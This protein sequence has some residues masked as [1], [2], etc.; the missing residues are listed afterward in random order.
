MDNIVVPFALYGAEKMFYDHR[1]GPQLV[2]DKDYLYC[3]YQA[4]ENTVLTDPYIVRYS[5]TEKRWAGPFKV[6]IG[7]KSGYDHHLTP[8]MWFDADG[9]IHVLF[10]CHGGMGTHRVSVKPFDIENFTDGPVI[11]PS[12]SY[13]HVFRME[14]NDVGL[15]FRAFGHMGYWG[16]CISHDGGYTWS[17]M[18]KVVDFD[19][20]P[21]NDADTWAGSYHTVELDEDGHTLHVAF[22]YFDE[23]GIWILD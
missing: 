19:Q 7:D 22:T 14:G 11:S 9:Y 10:N 21:L 1:M 15:F 6:G 3:V 2:R 23:R 16:Y 20:D 12:M 5:I 4:G 18:V 17:K 13:P 8:V